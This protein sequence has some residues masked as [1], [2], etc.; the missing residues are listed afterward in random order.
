[1]AVAQSPEARIRALTGGGN[2][3]SPSP[4]ERMLAEAC[5]LF[6]TRGIRAVGVDLLIARAGVAKASLYR[7]FP[8]K[9]ALV[10]AYVERRQEAWLTWLRGDVDGRSDGRGG[11]LAVFDGLANL[12]VDPDFRGDALVNAIAELGVDTPGLAEVA[13]RHRTALLD[14]IASLARAARLD[15]VRDVAEQW[16]HLIG[17]AMVAA[18]QSRDAGPAE[19]ARTIARAL[20]DGREP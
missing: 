19:T 16:V 9:Q 14:Y 12:F 20:L 8:S 15:R 10:V 17:G 18:Q 6:Y 7:H 13:A 5:V 4:R 2:D 3:G 1:M 11:L